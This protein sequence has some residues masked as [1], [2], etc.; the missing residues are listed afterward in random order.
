MLRKAYLKKL[1]ARLEDWVDEVSRLR[2]DAENAKTDMK[3]KYREQLE[4]LRSRQELALQR[5]RELR[6]AGEGNWGKF[7]SG[8]EEA[9][10]DLKKAVQ[11]AIEKLRK[12]A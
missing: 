10:E 3:M 6:E 11:D 12:S 8:A 2:E 5:I 1:E 9:V 4:V 7:K